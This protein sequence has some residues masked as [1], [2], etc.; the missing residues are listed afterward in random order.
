MSGAETVL[1]TGGAGYVGSHACKSLAA[2]GFLPVTYDDLSRGHEEAVR[3]GPLE[4]GDIGDGDRLEAVMKQYK[5]QAVMH[6]AGLIEVGES[7]V[8]PA[9]FY[10]TNVGGMLALLGAMDRAGVRDLV[11]S[12]TCAVYG[13]AQSLPLKEDHPLLPIN[14]YGATKLMAERMMEDFA[15]GQDLRFAALRYFNVAGADPQGE[16]G[17]AHHP[18]THLVPNLI[19]T[20]LGR[21]ESFDLFGTDFSTSD[22]TA[23]RDF[24]H[25][26]DLVEAHIRALDYLREGGPSL[27]LNLGTGAGFSVRQVITAVEA[28]AGGPIKVKECARRPGDAE[29][30]VADG[31]KA[32]AVLDWRPAMS[33]LETIVETAW[34]WHVAQGEKS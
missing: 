22:G 11:F 10:Q 1:V 16:T 24:I 14:P 4:R 2:A 28:L 17:E 27:A 13:A 20:G 6:F 7:V 8:N 34:R 9:L 5:P 25:V 12:S 18:E 31:Q 29:E 23:V 19:L 26:V 15:L 30:L 33:D 32:L 3:W 21:R